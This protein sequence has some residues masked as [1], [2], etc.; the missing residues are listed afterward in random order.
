MKLTKCGDCGVEIE[1]VRIKNLNRCEE[2]RKSA[3]VRD[4]NKWKKG[5]TVSLDNIDPKWLKR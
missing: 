3:R 1:V 5:R 2:C 4:T